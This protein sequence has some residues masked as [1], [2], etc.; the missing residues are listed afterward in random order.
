M[1]DN[2]W[3][4]TIGSKLL[5]CQA[6]VDLAQEVAVPKAYQAKY[7]MRTSISEALY[8]WG[9]DE[10]E[11]CKDSEDKCADYF[12]RRAPI[13]AARYA[14]VDAILRDVDHFA[15]TGKLTMRFSSVLLAVELASYLQEA[16][17]YFFG[18]KVMEALEDS[19]KSFVPERKK[20]SMRARVY[21]ALPK[22][23]SAEDL[24]KFYSNKKTI[25]NYISEWKKNGFIAK[26]KNLYV[27][28]V[29]NI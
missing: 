11:R 18:Q 26:V 29:N 4:R 22:E 2:H 5:K 3:L 21:A 27:K 24:L 25:M 19:S 6:P 23:F 8:Q 9:L 1:E 13:I 10:A 15:Q 17:M 28:L 12:R 7:G 16:Q 14:A 20:D